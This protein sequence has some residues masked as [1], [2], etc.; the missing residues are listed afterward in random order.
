MLARRPMRTFSLVTVASL[1][2]AGT[3]YAQQN[4]AAAPAGPGV[5]DVAPDFTLVGATRY[6]LLQTPVRLSDY[7]GRTVVLA[8]FY[9]ARTK[10]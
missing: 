5:N 4:A 6:G 2:A 7:R 8:F 1:V 10:G 3:G 9:Q